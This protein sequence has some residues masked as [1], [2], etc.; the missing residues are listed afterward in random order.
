MLLVIWQPVAVALPVFV[1]VSWYVT[2]SVGAGPTYACAVAAVPVP[3]KL[4]VGAFV[5]PL[6]VQPLPPFVI[7]TPTTVYGPVLTPG[8]YTGF[9]KTVATTPVQPLPLIETVGGVL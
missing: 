4:T 2:V 9:V 6:P 8:T 7:A 5:R 3:R 1:S